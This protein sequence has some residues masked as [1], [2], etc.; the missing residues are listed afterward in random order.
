MFYTIY[1]T[2]NNINGKYYIGK[3]KT[4]DLDDNYLGSGTMLKRAI[5]KHGIN[6]FVKEYLFIFDNEEDMNNKEAELVSEEFIKEDTNYN[7]ALGGRGSWSYANNHP[8]QEEYRKLARDTFQNLLK[9]DN[10]RNRFSK[11]IFDIWKN[12]SDIDKNI[13][14][15]NLKRASKIA[16]KNHPNGTFFGKK[17]T[18]EF[19]EHI[20]KINSIKQKGSNNSQYGM[21]W[22]YSLEE[23]I[24]KRISKDEFIPEG[25]YKGRKM[26]F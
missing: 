17:H 11:T 13:T 25:W 9:D 19:K 2:T 22:I 4:R 24:S 16:Q 23:K 15:E 12:K 20:G 18:E 1:K 21:M 3:H 26:K 5:K 10:Y 14:L 7:L 6:N 8:L